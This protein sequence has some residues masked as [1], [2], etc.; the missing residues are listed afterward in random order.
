MS[1][2]DMRN[3]DLLRDKFFDAFLDIFRE[4]II[5]VVEEE[6][7]FAWKGSKFFIRHVAYAFHGIDKFGVCHRFIGII[8]VFD[9]L[10]E[11]T[12]VMID[13]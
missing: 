12:H 2:S 13:G 8:V 3:N 5:V 1:V 4:E 10:L 9:F 6:N 7:G 11:I